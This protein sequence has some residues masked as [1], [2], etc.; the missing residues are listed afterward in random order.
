MSTDWPFEAV[1]GSSVADMAGVIDCGRD[2][3]WGN[4]GF[5][6]VHGEMMAK[7]LRDR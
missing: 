2:L 7:S 1:R 5:R 6:H 4:Q 3:G